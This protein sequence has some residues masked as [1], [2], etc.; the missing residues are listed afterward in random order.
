MDKVVL[1]QRSCPIKSMKRSEGIHRKY[2][3]LLVTGP[4][5]R[6]QCKPRQLEEDIRA[7]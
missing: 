2:S 5:G 3:R 7:L 4:L 1:I 6:L